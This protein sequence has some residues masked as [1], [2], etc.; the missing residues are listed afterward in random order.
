MEL[1][2]WTYPEPIGIIIR[3]IFFLFP[4]HCAVWKSFFFFFFWRERRERKRS[5]LKIMSRADTARTRRDL[6]VK[7]THW[8]L[9]GY[10]ADQWSRRL[11]IVSQHPVRPVKILGFLFGCDAFYFIFIFSPTIFCV[12]LRQSS[13]DFHE[14]A[15]TAQK[16]KSFFKN[17]IQLGGLGLVTKSHTFFLLM[18]SIWNLVEEKNKMDSRRATLV[19]P[20]LV[21]S[22]RTAN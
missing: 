14:I 17:E 20:D 7:N 8:E 5:D 18:M 13:T 16:R 22:I 1:F 10:L 11:P 12:A 2:V 4:H 15:S 19:S 21:Q 3:S 6:W 9:W